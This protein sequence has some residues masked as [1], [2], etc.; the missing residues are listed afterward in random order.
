MSRALSFLSRFRPFSYRTA[1]SLS[2][3]AKQYL[4][5]IATP[6]QEFSAAEFSREIQRLHQIAQPKYGRVYPFPFG[7]DTGSSMLPEVI[8]SIVEANTK[9]QK[10]G[11]NAEEIDKQKTAI[12]HKFCAEGTNPDFPKVHFCS[13]TSQANKLLVHAVSN[14]NYNHGEI[15]LASEDSH[16]FAHE[17]GQ[18]AEKVIPQDRLTSKL[19]VKDLQK[20]FS[21]FEGL[22]KR[23]KAIHLDQPTKGDYF[24]SPSEIKAITT[25]AHA[26]GLCVTMDVERLVNYLP[27]SHKDYENF[28]ADCEIDAVAFGMQKNGGPRSSVVVVLDDKYISDAKYL[29]Q[30]MRSFT[31]FLGN[32]T[33]N[34][35]FI[36]AGWNVIM[37]ND[38]YKEAATRAN[39]HSN[40]IAEALSKFDFVTG[41]S[42]EKL[43]AAELTQNFPLTTNMIF[44]KLPRDFI[45]LFNRISDLTGEKHF[46]LSPDRKGVTRI[47]SAH[48]VSDA[49]TENFISHLNLAY[50]IYQEIAKGKKLEEFQDLIDEQKSKSTKI[51][52]EEGLDMSEIKE[53][54]TSLVKKFSVNMAAENRLAPAQKLKLNR[55]E[56]PLD[57]EVM[58]EIFAKNIEGYHQPYGEDEIS[59]EVK[60]LLRE[61]FD[62]NS[63]APIAFTSSKE[64]GAACVAQFLKA[65]RESVVL[66]AECPG[67]YHHKFSRNVKSLDL[68]PENAKTGK[69]DPKGMSAVI[70]RHNSNSGKHVPLIAGVMLQQ[71]TSTGYIYSKEEIR[72]IA[73]L[74]H[75]HN[76]PLVLQMNGF[77]YHLARMGQNYKDYTTDCGVDV[78]TIG[79]SGIGGSISSAVI[80][81]DEKYL[82]YQSTDK[83]HLQLLFDRIVK[84]NGGKT[85]DS[86]SL[87]IGWGVLMK[88][89]RWRENA[90]IVNRHV[91]ELMKYFQELGEKKNGELEV[92]NP[93]TQSNIIA[94][95]MS[96]E[97]LA[98]LNSKGYDFEKDRDELVRLKVTYNLENAER[99][100]FQED[101]LAALQE[102]QLNKV[103]SA[104]IRVPGVLRL[105]Q[106]AAMENSLA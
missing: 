73:S 94:L 27:V 77:S 106:E 79:W 13:S 42:A 54:F 40:K 98:C 10:A 34:P 2:A 63:K 57:A 15:A 92:L 100:K 23:V 39:T 90:A 71:P 96:D 46:K 101:F 28:T 60:D 80:V 49:E 81:L 11:F 9:L 50:Q 62:I 29:E 76:I 82:P 55:N 25:W 51:S 44:V 18:P 4:Q 5:N 52:A 68:P 59:G 33:D 72:E 19:T 41:A 35:T 22:G 58:W 1:A 32:V 31:R 105:Q 20:S 17:V 69:M 61:K 89:E 74:A 91:D 26:N 99:E 7:S 64:Q 104:G 75:Q 67:Y 21:Y 38:T 86:S 66:V 70:S 37:N 8:A 36:T 6:S 103:P 43:S 65:T 84:E 85:S 102:V 45:N 24:Y 87:V 53:I 12:A 47:V 16:I 78:C 14:I 88:D 83:D 30:R 48:D 93:Q 56:V 97:L 95:K 3:N